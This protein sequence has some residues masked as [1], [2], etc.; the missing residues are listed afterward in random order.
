MGRIKPPDHP[1]YGNGGDFDKVP[2]PFVGYD[3]NTQEIILIEKDQAKAIQ[4]E[5]KEK[6]KSVLELIDSEYKI[7]FT[8]TY[9]Y[10]PIHSG[11]FL[12]TKPV[13]VKNIPDYITTRK[14]VLMTDADKQA[15]RNYRKKKSFQ[16]EQGKQIEEQKRQDA[17]KKLEA[18]GL[19][20]GDLK[21]IIK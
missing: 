4:Q 12:E 1:A 6:N 5:A 18:M 10:K 11:Q 20:E 2:H 7:N 9:D 3:S 16:Y 19:T 21:N 14:L 15:K 8:Q 13:L 17:I